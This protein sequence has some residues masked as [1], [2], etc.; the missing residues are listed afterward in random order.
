VVFWYLSRL[1]ENASLVH[2]DNTWPDEKLT[3]YSCNKEYNIV[4]KLN[5]KCRKCHNWR[6]QLHSTTNITCVHKLLFHQSISI[7]IKWARSSIFVYDEV[8]TAE[9]FPDKLPALPIFVRRQ[10]HIITT[11][12]TDFPPISIILCH[13]LESFRISFRQKKTAYCILFSFYAYKPARILP[14]I[15]M[16]AYLIVQKYKIEL[17]LSAKMWE[18]ANVFTGHF[19]SLSQS[20]QK[21]KFTQWTKENCFDWISCAEETNHPCD[22]SIAYSNMCDTYG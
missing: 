12:W 3:V 7:I 8:Q 11:L 15:I 9:W 1:I 19:I 17:L 21:G 2:H 18:N 14:N 6:S 5:E 10:H 22:Y 20:I 16:S 13:I 4:D